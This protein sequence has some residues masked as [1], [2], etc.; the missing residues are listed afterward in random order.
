MTD[1]STLETC[2]KHGLQFNRAHYRECEECRGAHIQTLTVETPFDPIWLKRFKLAGAALAGTLVLYVAIMLLLPKQR[3]ERSTT[4]PAVVG[5]ECVRTCTDR[6]E[7]CLLDC[8]SV[9]EDSCTAGC[10][11]TLESCA[12]RCQPPLQL[13]D[14]IAVI[15]GGPEG[16]ELDQ[17]LRGIYATWPEDDLPDRAYVRLTVSPSQGT[18]RE[19]QAL[20]RPSSAGAAIVK[21]LERAVFPTLAPGRDEIGRN[22]GVAPYVVYLA[23]KP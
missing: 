6:A 21:N 18:V 17:Q 22:Q 11:P 4:G 16:P 8:A 14:G 12:D 23:I 15:S 5:M 3:R 2:P 13:R 10:L 19:V 9:R 7:E 1:E 20:S